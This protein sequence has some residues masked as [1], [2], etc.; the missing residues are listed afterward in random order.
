MTADL[1]VL[2]TYLILLDFLILALLPLRL[3]F[4]I[5]FAAI[6]G[7]AFLLAVLGVLA[8]V[9]YFGAF[10]PLDEALGSFNGWMLG[11][12]AF[13]VSFPVA[14]V[15]WGIRRLLGRKG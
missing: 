13:L 14:L 5:C 9:V 11:F 10:P 4:G 12:L 6:F 7:Q 8:P 15:A 1:P 3:H 2:V